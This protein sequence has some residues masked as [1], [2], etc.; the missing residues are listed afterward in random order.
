MRR[1]LLLGA[2]ALTVAAAGVVAAMVPTP[3]TGS[4]GDAHITRLFMPAIKADCRERAG[5]P[6]TTAVGYV[7]TAVGALVTIDH[8]GALTGL[9]AGILATLNACLAQ[10]PILPSLEPPRDHYSRNLLYD[11]FSGVLRP[12]L[13]GRVDPETLPPL[14]SRA[15][16][17]VRLA[18]WDPYR[19][20]AGGR[21]LA[22]LIEL[23][24]ACPE[25]PSYLQDV[26]PG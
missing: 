2:A 17:V 22:Q 12:C 4:S 11:Y 1:S 14:P 15:D 21:T 24:T 9:D 3:H 19:F 26:P 5:V 25:R 20:L 10:Y 18:N 7:F 23:S 6:P 16:F 13:A 8:D